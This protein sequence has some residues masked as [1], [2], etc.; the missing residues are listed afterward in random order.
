MVGISTLLYKDKEADLVYRTAKNAMSRLYSK[1]E[2]GKMCVEQNVWTPLVENKL[3]SPMIM[4]INE[5]EDTFMVF[6]PK[7]PANYVFEDKEYNLEVEILSGSIYDRSHNKKY[8]SGDKFT[9]HCG[10][11]LIPIT[12]GEEAYI[13]VKKV[14]A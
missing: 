10:E 12:L 4:G 1:L 9:V 11:K 6:Y 13:K 3:R 8:K 7:N 2:K 5:S 14:P